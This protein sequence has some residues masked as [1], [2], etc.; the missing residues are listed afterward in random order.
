[1]YKNIDLSKYELHSIDYI[2]EITDT[3]TKCIDITVDIDSTFY[4]KN[5]IG[6]MLTHNCDGT[7][8]KGLL[9]NFIHKFWPELLELGF[10]FEF[11]TPIVI[12]K[13]GKE[14]KEYYNVTNY[15]E[16]TEKGKL[17]GYTIKYYKG[18]GTIKSEDMKAM[19]KN[20]PKHL[21]RFNYKKERD[22][23]KIDMLFKKERVNDRRDWLLSYKGEIVPDKFGKANEINEFID[24]E[25]IQFSNADNIRSI[26]NLIDGL[27]PSQRKIM[28]SAFKEL[29]NTE[30]DETKVEEF[31]A[32]TSKISA[33]HHGSVSLEQAIVGM[34]QDFVGANNIPL[35]WPSGQFGSRSNPD[36]YASARYTYTYFNP[37]TKLIFRKEDENI[38]NYLNEDGKS[39]E[40]DFYL[41]IIPTLLVNGSDGI[42]TGWSTNI[43]KYSP[44]SIIKVI[45]KKI[46]K[47]AIKYHIIPDFKGWNGE[48][49]WN[50]E[51]NCYVSNGIY[52]KS[53][54][55][56]LITELPINVWT[57]K[58]I[59]FL[60]NLCDD[61]KI[62]NYIDNST[63]DT[64]HIEIMLQE[65]TK[66]IEI[67]NL[68][69]LSSNISLN[70][71]HTFL[72][73]KIIKWN[74]TEELLD[75]WFTIRLAYYKKRKKSWIEV[76][77]DK[78]DKYYNILC[79]LK[80]VIDGEIVINNRKKELIVN[81]LTEMEFITIN[82]TFD[83][84]LNIPVYHFT[85]EKY[86]EYKNMAKDMK[87]ELAE[88]KS[89]NPE[90]IWIK[91]LTELETALKKAGY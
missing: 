28:F 71:M 45:K 78:Y 33:Y 12:A 20:L 21:I 15:H 14:V 85:K 62:R 4:V 79:F 47:P 76:L 8:I 77:Q 13:K 84:L 35:L 43:S 38:L 86:D 36:A 88:Y 1:M 50:E 87:V 2:K 46:E 39:I 18:L 42:G 41:P 51:K 40:P 68:L 11:I 23:D 34:A 60:D 66:D 64:V 83:Y 5:N 57:E 65:D 25:F 75:K 29:G 63:D 56:I 48:L 3:E 55:G 30:K 53:K 70:N 16:D 49:E 91:D 80:A 17:A 90:D 27:K 32:A 10:C 7:S 72:D 81:D 89:L 44:L 82:D 67:P 73:N 58:Y 37:L 24:N 59:T 54:K 61:K 74:T 69:K 52:S 6:Y 26:P 31:A 19:F 9:I 22:S